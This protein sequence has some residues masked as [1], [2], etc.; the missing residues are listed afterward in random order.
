MSPKWDVYRFDGDHIRTRVGSKMLTILS[1][2]MPLLRVTTTMERRNVCQH[3]YRWKH[4]ATMHKQ[5]SWIVTEKN[6]T[7]A[8]MQSTAMCCML[9]MPKVGSRHWWGER[10]GSLQS[11]LQSRGSWSHVWSE[12]CHIPQSQERIYRVRERPVWSR[13]RSKC[14]FHSEEHR[15]PDERGYTREE[16]CVTG[17]HMRVKNGFYEAEHCSACRAIHIHGSFSKI[18]LCYPTSTLFQRWVAAIMVQIII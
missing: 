15:S 17:K 12:V 5:K 13:L 4:T 6:H 7:N 1:A 8:W 2:S 18:A 10:V 9:G 16:S 14:L 11:M 3:N